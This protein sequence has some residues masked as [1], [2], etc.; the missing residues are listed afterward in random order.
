MKNTVE[1]RVL[2]KK[3]YSEALAKEKRDR[4]NEKEKGEEADESSSASSGD[5]ELEEISE[6]KRSTRKSHSSDYSISYIFFISF[7]VSVLFFIH[8]YLPLKTINHP[9]LHLRHQSQL[10]HLT[11]PH[12]H[13]VLHLLRYQGFLFFPVLFF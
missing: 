13:Q 6:Q 10:K 4:E 11:S 9:P 1:N 12:H 5:F 8:Q 2:C 7:S 3:I